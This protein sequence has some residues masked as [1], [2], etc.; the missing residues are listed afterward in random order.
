MGICI[1]SP[2]GSVVALCGMIGLA[3]RISSMVVLKWVA[4]AIRLSPFCAVYS[5][6]VPGSYC[7]RGGSAVEGTNVSFGSGLGV[8]DAVEIE[9]AGNSVVACGR[10]ADNAIASIVTNAPRDL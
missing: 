8:G 5:T 4:K 3:I 2:A 10:H 1:G 6:K 7:G 9:G